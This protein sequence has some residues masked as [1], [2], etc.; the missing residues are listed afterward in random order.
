MTHFT[1]IQQTIFDLSQRIVKAQQPIRILDAIKWDS[2]IKSEF[3]KHKFMQLP[4]VDQSYYQ[5]NPLGFDPNNKIDEF[6]SIEHDIKRQLGEYGPA[7]ELMQ[8]RCHEYRDS[9]EMLKSRGTR[10][11]AEI[12]QD[13]YG[14][15]EDAFYPGAPTLKNLSTLVNEVLINLGD[16]TL[17][18]KDE[19]IFTADEAVKILT[20]RLKRYFGSDSTVQ[21]KID[22]NIISDASAGADTLRIRKDVKFSERVLHLY[23][24]HEGW[25]HLGTTFNGQLQPI[26]TFLSKGPPSATTTQEGLAMLAEIFSFASYPERVK[27]LNNRIIA[28]HMAE[29]GAN[30]IEIF[31]FFREQHLNEEESYQNTVRI[32]RGSTPTL[33]PFTKDLSYSKGFILV[34]NYIRLCIQR[35][36]LTNIPLLFAGK[37]TL[38]DIHY[39]VELYEEG[40]IKYPK[41]IPAQF[42][43]LAAVCAW[44]SYSLFFNRVNSEEIAKDFRDIL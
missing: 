21:V 39:L 13:L 9:V 32:F 43:D 18:K 6:F 3:F 25:V 41:Y 14:S 4:D 35:G 19:K 37:T 8:H 26:C 1:P 16:K 30:F 42:R 10:R 5:K 29:Q 12:A 40:I 15:A 24:V 33:G 22:D 2:H 7:S 27:R 11:F 20:R 38:Q 31:N 44:A 36:N 28:I 34:Y 17:D 23:E